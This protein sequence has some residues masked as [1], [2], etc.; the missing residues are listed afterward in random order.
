[1]SVSAGATRMA[2]TDARRLT[3]MART[4][5]RRGGALQSTAA[6]ERI[7]A[8]VLRRAL[9]RQI[10]AEADR[11]PA[12]DAPD[13]AAERAAAVDIVA[14]AERALARADGGAG[15]GALSDHEVASL[16]AIIEVV[17]RPALR[18]LDGRVEMP[19]SDLGENE[20]WRVLV[21]IARSKIDRVSASV[22]RIALDRPGAPPD[23]VGTGWRIGADLIVTN[24]HVAGRLVTDPTR[25][26]ARWA[27]DPAKTAVID[28]TVTHGAPSPKRFRL[29]ALAYC[30]GEPEIDLAVLRLAPGTAPVPAPVPL[31]LAPASLGDAVPGAGGVAVFKGREVYVVGH[32]DGQ[33]STAVRRVF[34][35]ADGRKRCSPG[36]VTTLDPRDP[37]LE[38]DCSTLGGN[39]GSCVFA[40][41]GHAA[42]GLHHGGRGVD[43]VTARGESNVAIA[44]ARLGAHR[45]ATILRE[46][47]V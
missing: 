22:G 14:H 10:E 15:P 25:P 3:S 29:D 47:H 31:D 35:A 26:P 8:D 13:R 19:A 21:A 16:Q 37:V 1:M 38:H 30:A 23:S 28:F 6:G 17:G 11:A 27:L 2:A 45:A 18:Y 32:P 44:L 4:L 9:E 24:R 20:R 39:S 12:V 7:D 42:V 40:A 34:G 43:P 33:A 5:L 36:V 41:G 46:G